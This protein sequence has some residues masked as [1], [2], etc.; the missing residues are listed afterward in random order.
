VRA[1]PFDEVVRMVDSGEIVDA[2][3]IVAVLQALRRRDARPAGA[4]P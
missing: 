4:A 1:F 3:T 2:M